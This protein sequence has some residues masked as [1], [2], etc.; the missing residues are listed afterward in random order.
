ML[1]L[2]TV[3]KIRY[4]DERGLSTKI[5]DVMAEKYTGKELAVFKSSNELAGE[6]VCRLY[7]ARAS[8][9]GKHNGV[10]N[11]SIF[12]NPFRVPAS[13]C[14]RDS[15]PEDLSQEIFDGLTGG[16]FEGDVECQKLELVPERTGFVKNDALFGLCIE[17][18]KW[19]E[20]EGAKYVLE[21][22]NSG[23]D[24]L[25]KKTGL[26]AMQFLEALCRLT[27]YKSLLAYLNT[28][29]IGK[30][31]DGI[32]GPALGQEGKKPTDEK[33][34]KIIVGRK[35][36]NGSERKDHPPET[37]G[38]PK[39]KVHR[40]IDGHSL[41][42]HFQYAQMFA[43]TVYEFDQKT[44]VLTFNYSHRLWV[45]CDA[46]SESA[47]ARYQASVAQVVLVLLP[48]YGSTTIELQQEI[49]L[50]FLEMEVRSIIDGE[51]FFTNRKVVRQ[52]I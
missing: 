14:L 23:Q 46:K 33:E 50:E 3:V 12:N 20:Q 45:M 44:G 21:V 41:G 10:V 48:Y 11:V 27:E 30:S 15:V 9:G 5:V 24:A 49:L 47:L 26:R 40:Q 8:S 17:L 28:S 37:A 29:K 13:E 25:F 51:S 38:G 22:K 42:I 7:L 1:M 34:N 43:D 52:V 31:K 35:R 36:G 18:V 19:Y 6:V 4:T 16:I 2:G 32:D 39:A